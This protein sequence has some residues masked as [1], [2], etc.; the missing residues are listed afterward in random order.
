MQVNPE[1]IRFNYY[2]LGRGK[3]AE[4]EA[5]YLPTGESVAESI[6]AGSTETDRT[7]HARLLSALKMKIQA[8]G[9]TRAGKTTTRRRRRNAP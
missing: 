8:E 9:Q 1:E 5:I 2:H 6:P 4:I 7:L 3:G